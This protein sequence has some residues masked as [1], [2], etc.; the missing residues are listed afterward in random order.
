[1][2]PLPECMSVFHAGAWC[3]QKPVEGIK[4]L[5][6]ELQTDLSNHGGAGTRTRVF[7][8]S[9]QCSSLLSHLSG[10]YLFLF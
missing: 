7:W 9:N 4:L 1:M 6:L 2:G 10:L 5:R 3:L 8:K